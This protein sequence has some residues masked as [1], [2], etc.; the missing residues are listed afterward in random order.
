VSAA[1]QT[2]RR[3]VTTAAGVVLLAGPTALAFFSGGYFETPRVWA[4]LVAWVLVAVAALTTR[5]PLA[6]TAAG[7][8]AQLA[9]L[10]FALWTL[11]STFWAPIAGTAYGAG[12]VAMLYAGAL[13][14]SAALLRGPDIRRAVEPGLAAGTAIVIGYGL[15]A[16]LLPGLLHFQR[17]ISAEGRLEQ[18][19]T[20]WNAMGELAALGFVLCVRLAGDGTRPRA[21]R[22][23][24]AAATAPLGLGLYLSVSRGALFACAAGLVALIVLAPRRAQLSSLGVAVAAGLVAS[25]A[26]APSSGVTSLAGPL[27]TRER[28]GAITLV[29]LLVV[30][31]AAAGAQLILARREGDRPLRL[32]RRSPLIALGVVCAGLALA[33]VVGSKESSAQPLATGAAR[34]ATL[35]SNRYA[36]WDV[37]LRAFAAQPLRGIG[38]G[39]WAV[40]WLRYRTVTEGAQDAH[41]LQLQTLAE[42]GLVGL[43]LLL[44]CLGGTA[45]AA[46][47]AH[48]LLPGAAAGPVAALVT[49]LVHSPLDWDWQMPAVTLVAVVLAG[50]VLALA[51]GGVGGGSESATDRGRDHRQ[52]PEG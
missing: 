51:E 41:S 40:Y 1:P 19:L 35:Q 16:R 31:V 39:G 5:R 11:A 49:Y 2:S 29:A 14:A 13:I 7:R 38:A 3:V 6:T 26:A 25:L 36:Y 44:A 24:A 52:V 42:L 46:A 28:Q 37:A 33:I 23:A 30:M 15:S 48:R 10:G 17:S 27:A 12:Q 32:P 9:L 4:G 43:A 20:Y 50:S 22:L 34:Y 45:A 18:P 8:V 47:R 21:V